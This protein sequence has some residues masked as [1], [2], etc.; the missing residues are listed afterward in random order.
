MTARSTTVLLCGAGPTKKISN[1]VDKNGE[2]NTELNIYAG[3]TLLKSLTS[4][5]NVKY[6]IC[7]SNT[8]ASVFDCVTTCAKTT[9]K[10]DGQAEFKQVGG[11]LFSLGALSN[12]SITTRGT[13]R[14]NITVHLYSAYRGMLEKMSKAKDFFLSIVFQQCH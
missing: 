6:H 3:S 2:G 10:R 5:R 9:G 11:S 12:N 1:D 8:A 7:P 4:A 13:D 14:V